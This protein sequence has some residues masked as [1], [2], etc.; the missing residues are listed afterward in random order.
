MSQT[1]PNW[2]STKDKD[3]PN[4]AFPKITSA[5]SESRV[6]PT[7]QSKQV[8]YQDKSNPFF[9]LS[10]SDDSGDEE[11]V[12]VPSIQ[13][14]NQTNQSIFSNNTS[15]SFLLDMEE[16]RITQIFETL[17]AKH[18]TTKA[19][20]RPKI[21]LVLLNNTNYDDWAKKIKYSLQLNKLW[22]DPTKNKED[23][24]ETE[25]EIN[26]NAFLFLAC[27]L[28][29]QNGNL[30]NSSNENCFITTWNDINIHFKPRRSTVLADIISTLK[31]LNHQSNEPVASHLMKLEK[32]FSR[33]SEIGQAM[34]EEVKV[35]HILASI[36]NSPDFANIFHSALW[37]D[38]STLTVAKAKSI[39]ISTQRN[40]LNSESAH[41]SKQLWSKQKFPQRNSRTPR[42]PMKG[43]RCPSC[44]MDNHS[45]EECTK[46]RPSSKRENNRKNANQATEVSQDI[47]ESSSVAS[48]Y[49]SNSRAHQA[50]NA[51]IN[52]SP[53]QGSILSRLGP[54]LKRRRS[55]GA[56]K[57]SRFCKTAS[58]SNEYYS[59]SSE[60]D[61]DSKDDLLLL[62]HDL[63]EM[64][65]DMLFD[66][67][68]GNSS[69]LVKINNVNHNSFQKL[70]NQCETLF[71]HTHQSITKH[72]MLNNDEPICM[73]YLI[74]QKS[75]R[76]NKLNCMNYISNSIVN[77]VF[78]SQKLRNKRLNSTNNSKYQSKW[79]VDSGA[80]LHISSHSNILSDFIHHSGD[81]VVI[82]DGSKI[83]IKGYGTL[84]FTLRDKI[85][86]STHDIVMKNVAFVP[87]FSV[88]LISVKALTSLQGCVK[89]TNSACFLEHD[90]ISIELAKAINSAYVL[91]ILHN[92]EQNNQTAYTCIHDWHRKMGHKN[93]SDL[94]VAIK[95][96]KLPV[97]KCN[98][99]NECIS[100]LKGKFH[101]LPF[102]KQ[103]EKPKQ[104]REVI[105]TDLCGPFKTQSLGGSKYFVTFTCV[106]TDY[107]E[108][109]A[110]RNKSD[111]KTELVNYIERCKTQF[112]T[113]IKILRSDRGGEYLDT[114][115]QNYL[116]SN[117][118]IFQCSTPRCPQQNGISERKNRTLTEALRTMLIGKNLP[119]FLWA[120]A[121][122]H[123]NNTLNMIPKGADKLS[124]KEKFFNQLFNKSFIEFGTK[125]FYLTNTENRSKLDEKGIEG[126]FVGFDFNSKGYRIYSGG[127]I[128]IERHV[129]IL[130]SSTNESNNLTPDIDD[131][132]INDIPKESISSDSP[133]RSE[134][135]KAQQ[136]HTTKTNYYEPKTYKQ[137]IS[138]EDKDKWLLAMTEELTSIHDNNTWSI[139]DLPNGRTA[140]GCRW[141]FKL[142]DCDD[143]KRYKARLVAQ[144]FTQKYG[145]DY[146]EVFAPVTRS[147]TFRILLTIASARKYV[148]KQYDV[149]T[150][151]LNG[152][153]SEEIYMKPPPG[154]QET[155]QVLKLHKS[156]YGL[157]QA[158]RV[159]NQT[160]KTAMVSVNFNQSKSDECLFIFKDQSHICYAIVHVDDM[161]FASDSVEL[162]ER[163]VTELNKSFGLKCLGDVKNYL[164]IEVSKDDK[165]AFSLCQTK[166]IDKIALDSQLQDSK[167]AKFPLDPGYHKLTDENHLENNTEYRKIIGKLLYISTNT[168]PDISAAVGILAQRVS[169]PRS[170]DYNEALRIIRYLTHTKTL[171]LHL[172]DQS[173]Q[174]PLITYADSDW[175]EDR[176]S[177][178]SISGVIVKV[179]GG[180]A[181]WSSRKQ[182]IV[183]T[184]TTE[185]E[186]YA[187]SEAVKESLWLSHILK[188]FD[189]NVEH[190]LPI[191]SD[192]QSTIKMVENSKF[193][194]RTKHIDVR[195]HFVRD[196]VDKEII[197]INYIPSEDNVAD[198]LTKPLAGIK[199]QHLRRLASL[200]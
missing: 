22:I 52:A 55:I 160:L 164:G 181:S 196:N 14:S 17:F 144:G 113:A 44:Q 54:N 163:L 157:K 168:R 100:C 119:N 24:N 124:P 61:L 178:K 138:C 63:S 189:I 111:C 48:A 41:Q 185:A 179:F 80:T 53:E 84:S 40:V 83:P 125:V 122:Y 115:V 78:C 33:L 123:A 198:L 62:N 67:S 39:L 15:N 72:K 88:N 91:T 8:L 34:N 167:G 93:I 110:I 7:R 58:S 158:A 195:L 150:A 191:R 4:C 73:N 16:Q 155:N 161:I 20:S 194:S 177:R 19:I 35:A 82:S 176:T 101:A 120:E 77:N 137:A 152:N 106:N 117:G 156:L 192:N 107:T 154:Y 5:S 186:F 148:V 6:Q 175:A 140:I 32:Q 56:N 184:S 162:I 121:L 149:K 104:P 45:K 81:C 108:V 27:H 153:L 65:E 97:S 126:I 79:I 12:E 57:T 96:L 50:S 142:K 11:E 190:P 25:S 180:P 129:K 59:S 10:I 2:G 66:S 199:I 145:E 29:E 134:R 74:N 182:D 21:D 1:E 69:K 128:R 98:C 75:N 23:L 87:D 131:F 92:S 28:D 169:K 68:T 151:F 174:T 188:D 9:I 132:M 3:D 86:N 99:S 197:K 166:Y 133:R 89:F 38:V 173:N 118:I 30:I 146:D 36:K 46:S 43:Y 183:S 103:S 51:L 85:S 64:D 37:E 76:I 143:I 130:E 114:S 26:K 60:L 141:V 95:I 70:H 102:P 165:G 127:R 31:E 18:A 90:R 170:L 135:L 47:F 94:K 193:S 136:A 49:S 112:G 109:A 116:K 42:N 147:S 187:L 159:W 200:Y 71:S 13:S 171:K 105:T 172:F 139:V